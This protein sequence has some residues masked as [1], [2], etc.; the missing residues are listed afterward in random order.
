MRCVGIAYFSGTGNTW[1]IAEQYGGAFVD[2]GHRASLLRIEDLMRDQHLPA[3]EEYDL[4]G[5]G[6]PVHAWNA[7]RLAARFILH[8]PRSEGQQVFLFLTADGSI[9]GAFDW[10][11]TTLAR[12]GYAVIH[13]A[14]YYAGGCYLTPRSGPPSDAEAA[15]R[16]AWRETDVREA[17][18]E[19]LSGRERHSHA[20]DA[21]RFLL[22]CLAWRL[23]L[24][25]CRAS[26]RL[27]Q[28]DDRCPD[29]CDI[30]ARGCPTE[31]ISIVDSHVTFGVDC[32]LCLRCLG[33][34]PE[35]AIHFR[36]I[37]REIAPDMEPG[38]VTAL[39]QMLDADQARRREG[40]LG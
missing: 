17:V 11:R 10:A 15:R 21:A 16:L 33:I 9:G 1:R 27:L 6:Y 18:E 40:G 30:C 22:S 4:L 5:I 13:E 26:G 8:M 37:G 35:Q 28:A 2:R 31:S 7:P 20:G 29:G 39:Q 32:T 25:G 19:I 38:Y 3:L 36:L 24:L 23:Y 34:C 14:R 12:A